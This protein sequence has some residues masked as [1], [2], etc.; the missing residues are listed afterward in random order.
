GEYFS[1]RTNLHPEIFP[2]DRPMLYDHGVDP[3]LQHTIIGR[4]NAKTMEQDDLG[5]WVEAQLDRHGRYFK[6]L[7]ALMDKG[8]LYGSTSAPTALVKKAADGEILDWPVFEQTL[9]PIPCNAF[10]RIEP[11]MARKHYLEAGLPFP[12]VTLGDE[13][14]YSAA[15]V[16]RVI[17]AAN[18]LAGVLSKASGYN[19]HDNSV[20]AQPHEFAYID[21]DGRGHLPIPDAAHVRAALARFDQEQFPDEAT[22]RKAYAAILAAAKKFGVTVSDDAGEKSARGWEAKAGQVLN[23]ANLAH[24]QSI[25]DHAKSMAASMGADACK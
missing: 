14:R 8:A 12:T 23:K 6:A 25:H 3:L 10:S 7:K 22:K 1:P 17:A 21:K 11:A 9:T 19:I 5:W 16:A 4:T 15:S 20:G 18:G 2:G 13:S 24:V